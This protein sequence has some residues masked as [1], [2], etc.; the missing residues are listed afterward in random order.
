LWDTTTVTNQIQLSLQESLSAGTYFD[1]VTVT[2]NLGQS[3]NLPITLTVSKADTITVTSGPSLTTVY[4]VTAPTNGP[5][6]R[7]TGLV[8]FDTATVTTSYTSAPG[9]TCA[10]G[11]SC[12]I[13]DIGPGGGYVFYISG[14]VIDSA[15]GIS[16]GG[17]YLEVAPKGWST[18]GSEYQGQ[19]AAA[20]TSVSGTSRSVG[21]GAENTRK[22]IAALPSTTNLA[23]ITADLTFGGK[24]DWFFP[25]SDEVKAMYT[26][27]Y[28]ASKGD[29]S[30][31]NYWAST[32]DDLNSSP[33]RADTYWFGAGNTYSPT[34]KLNSYF[35]RP[36][37]AFTPGATTVTSTPTDVD[38]YTVTGTNLTFGVGSANN[39]QAVVYETST[40]KITQANQNKLVLNLYGAVAGSPFT[41]VTTG[42]SGDGAVTETVTAGS[43]ASNCSVSN[44]VLS[45]SNSSTQQF[46]CNV[47]VTKASSRNYKS[48]SLTASVYFMVFINSQPTGLVGS[49]STIALNGVTSLETST[50]LP[51]SITALSV[52]SLSL[53]GGVTTFTIT[54]SGFTGTIT[55]KFWRN[56]II[57]ATSSD[58]TT[59]NI[60]VSSISAAGATSGRIAVITSAGEAVSIDSLTITP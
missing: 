28:A 15:T 42:G 12:S 58:G 50:V 47:L 18:P 2:D 27:V 43:T 3:T 55:V 48:E 36:I 17:T 6:A 9:S 25:S 21:Q 45:N 20:G 59:I 35:L 8:G 44:H 46:Y 1:T 57:S 52:S 13:G 54:G 19:W 10:T 49:G 33:S 41:L 31:S 30:A 29:F 7:V 51:P 16:D 26:N 24:S 32:Q 11:G 4:S 38:T 5:V 40:L 39:Y 56:K 23:K 22:I 37:R 34:D 14:T 60:P 53:S